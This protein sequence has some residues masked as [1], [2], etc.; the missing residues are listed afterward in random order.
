MKVDKGV[1]QVFDDVRY[2]LDRLRTVL[3]DWIH[4]WLLPRI[5]EAKL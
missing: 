3:S 2:A 4:G 1:L 5:P